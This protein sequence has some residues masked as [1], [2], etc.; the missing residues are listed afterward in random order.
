LL[1][2]QNEATIVTSV[3]NRCFDRSTMPNWC[4]RQYCVYYQVDE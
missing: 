3:V 4:R 2:E 1:D